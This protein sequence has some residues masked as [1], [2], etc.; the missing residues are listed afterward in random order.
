LTGC[1][2]G[3]KVHRRET[4]GTTASIGPDLP[5]VTH[6]AKAVCRWTLEDLSTAINVS[7]FTLLPQFMTHHVSVSW[8]LNGRQHIRHHLKSD[9]MLFVYKICVAHARN[10]TPRP[11]RINLN[12]QLDDAGKERKFC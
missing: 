12:G 9:S 2:Q 6:D 8:L 10:R 1:R 11:R 3:L 5:S 4:D 7:V